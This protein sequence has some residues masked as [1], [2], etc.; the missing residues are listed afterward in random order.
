MSTHYGWAQTYNTR[1]YANTQ[2][3]QVVG[4]CVCSVSNPANAVDAGTAAPG[5]LNTASTVSADVSLLGGTVYQEYIFSGATPKPAVTQGIILKVGSGS[6]LSLALLNSISLQAYNGATPVGAKIP[7]SGGLLNL[8]LLA[9]GNQAELF[10]PAPGGTGTYDRVRITIDGGLASVLVSLNV[11]AAYYDVPATGTIACDKPIDVL[12]GINGSVGALGGVTDAYKAGDGDPATFA[13]LSAAV[14]VA[15]YAQATAIF[16]G[17]SAP[18]DSVRLLV[19]QSGSLLNLTLLSGLSIVTYNGNTE[20][21]N[22]TASSGLLTLQLLSGS[23]SIQTLSF[24]PTAAFDRI[25]VR[26]GGVLNVLSTINV[27]EIQRVGQSPGAGGSA[28]RTTCFGTPLTLNVSNPDNVNLNYTW[29]DSTQLTVVGTG[30]SYIVPGTTA[31]GKYRYYVSA[32]RKTCTTESAKA[33]VNVQVNNFATAADVTLS[34]IPAACPGD[35]IRITPTSTTANKKPIFKWY[36]DAAKTT[37]ITDGQVNGLVKYNIDTTGK[38]SVTGLAAGTYNYFV[39]VSDSNYC[40]NAANNLKQATVTVGVGPAPPTLIQTYTVSTGL[41]LT[42]VATPAPGTTVIWY[43]NDTTS[44]SFANGS[45]V[46][47]PAFTV[48][49]TYTYFA[50]DSTP[51]GCISSRLQITVTVSGPI[52]TTSC[53]VPTSQVTGTTLGCVLCSVADPLSAIDADLTNFS[54]LNIPVG[55]LGGSVYQRVIFPAPGAATDSIRLDLASPGGLADVSLLGGAVVTV[56]NGATVVSTTTLSQL[57]TLRLLSS[58]RFIATVPTGGVYDRV[59]VKLTG[60]VNLLN[61]LDIYSVRAVGPN[62]TIAAKNVTVCAGLPA[63]F[64]ATA[65]PGTSLRWYKDSTGGTILSTQPAFT[66]D[67]LK[68]AGT[69]TYYVEVVDANGCANPERIPVTATVNALG[70]PADITV[71]G[72]NVT[73]GSAVATLTPTAAGVTTPVFKWYT[74]SLR[75]TAIIN[76]AVI[77]GATFTIDAAGKLSATGLALGSHTYF[78]SVSGTNRCENA[79][80]NLKS[81]TITV[82][83]NPAPPALIQT[84]TVTTGLP[85]TLMATPAPGAT[86]IWYRNDTTGT[87]FASGS[88]ITLPPF[89]APGVYSYFA[90][91]SI[92]GGCISSRLLITITVTGPVVTTSCNVPTSQVTGTTLGCVL[93][94]VANPTNDIDVDPANFTRLNIP[95]GLLGG[96]VYQQLIFPAAGAATDSIRLDLSSPG[97]LADV[98][99]LGGAVVTVYNGAT[100][101]STTTLSQLLTL[102]LL[103]GTRYIATVPTGGAYDRVEVKLTGVVNLLNSLDIYGVRAV[104]PNPT[105]AAKNV[106][107]CA[108]Q[109]AVFNATAGPGTSL[110]WYKD[111]TGGAFLSTQPTFTTDSLKTAGAFTYYVEVVDANG[112][113]NPERIPVI[114]TVN[115]L[116][117]PADITVTGNNATCGGAAATLVPTAA[118]VTA[119]VFKWYTDSLKTT[120]IINGAVIGG[121][122]FAIDTTGKLSVSGLAQGAHTYYVSVSGSNRCENAAGSLKSATI[123]VSGAPAPPAVVQTQAISTGLPL[124]L[125]AAGAPGT[126]VLWYS[127][128]TKA[129][130]ATGDS[131]TLPPF[132][133]PGIYTYYVGDSLAGGCKSSRLPITITVTG[134]VIPADCNVPTSQVTGTTLGCILCSVQNPANDIDSVPTNFTR[135]NI[136]VGLLGGSVYQRLIFPGVRNATDSIRL[137]LASPGGLADVSVLGGAVITVYNGATVVSTH[138]LSQLLTLRLLGG[139]RYTAA[140]AAGGAYDRVEVKLTGVANLLNSL[141]IYGVRAVVPDPTVTTQNVVV[142]AGQR[143]ALTVTPAAG[144]TVRWYTDSTTTVIKSTTNTYNTDTLKVA[145]KYTFYVQAIAANGCANPNRIPVIVTVNP[146]SQAGSITVAD[147]TT[148]CTSGPAVLTPTAAAVTAPVFRW[149]KNADKTSPVT[150]GL[151]EGTVSYA[152]DSATGKLTITGLATG[153]YTYYVSVS[154]TGQ[155]ENAAGTLKPATVHVVTA[156]ATPVVTGD[157]VVTTGVKAVL[158]AQPVPGATIVWYKDATTTTVEGTGDTIQVG[159]F[160]SPGTYTYYAAVQIPGACQSARVAVNVKVTGNFIPSPDCNVPTSQTSGT[161]LGCILCSVNNPTNDIDSVKTNFTTLSVPVGALGGSV[162]QQLIFPHAGTA[163]DSVQVRLGNSVGLADVSLL[164]GTLISLYNNNTLVKTD[165][166]SRLLTLRLLNGQQFTAT[167]VAPSAYNRVE[168]KM[169]GVLNLLNSIDIYG[170]RIIYPKATVNTTSAT[171]CINTKASLSVTPAAGTSVRWYADSTSNTVL[172][173]QNTYTTDTLKVAGKVTYYVAVLGGPDNCPNPERIPVTVTVTPAPPVP[174]APATVNICPGSDAVLQVT[175]PD[176]SLTYNWYSTATGGTKLNTDSGFVFTVKAIAKDTAF[177][178]EAVSSC[179]AAS[180]RQKISIV[181]SSSLSAP[182]VSPNPDS[183][184]IGRQTAV[185]ATSNAANAQ[186]IWYGSQAGTDS[187]FTGPVFTP[188]VSNTIGT[189]TYWVEARLTGGGTCKSIRVPAVIYY[190]PEPGPDPGPCE[191]AATQTIGGSGLLILG[192]VYNPALAVDGSLST[193]SSLV[194]NLGALNAQVWERVK[195]NG[196]SAPGDTVRVWLS[197]PSQVLSAALLGGVQLTTYN[198]ATPGDSLAVNNPLIKLTLLSS[199][200]QAILEF[201]PTKP[202]DGVEVKLKSGILGALTTVDFNYA[203]RALAAPNVKAASVTACAGSTATLE[204]LAPVTGVTY[205]WYNSKGVYLTGKD[206]VSFTSGALTADTS[207]FVEAFRNNCASSGRTKVDVKVVAAPAAPV[208]RAANVEVCAGSDALL[209]INNPVKGYSY[210]WYNVANGGTRLNPVPDSGLTFI[211]KNVTAQA[212]YYV[213]AKNDSCNTTSAT[214]TAVTVNTATALATPTVTPV[215]DTIVIGQRPVFTAKAAA[216]NAE[217]SWFR[218]QTDTAVLFKGTTFEGPASTALGTVTYWVEASLPGAATCKSARIAVNAITITPNGQVPC[219]G[220]TGQ[221]IGGSGLLVLGN[222]YNPQLAVDP[223]TST[224]SSLVINLGAVNAAV[225][226]KATF[227]GLST[228]G[229]TVRVMLSNP[230]QILSASLLGSVQL[231]TYNGNT[232]GDSVLTSNPILHLNLLS[233]GRSAILSFVP[234]KPFDGVEVKLR[235]G[236]VGTLL[237]VDFNYAQRAI[238]QPKVQV[239]NAT[240]CKG[241]QATLSVINPAPGITYSWYNNK[242]NH[243]LDSIAYVTPTTLDSGVYSYTVVPTRNTCPGAAS[244]ATTVTVLGLP[245]APVPTGN[246]ASTCLNTPVTLQVKAVA[247]IQYNWYDAATGGAKLVT[248]SNQYTTPASLQAGIYNFYV[249]AVNAGNCA[250]DSGRTKITL[251]VDSAATA[252]DIQIADKV[253][254]AGDTAVLTP[255]TTTVQNP[256][257]KWYANADRTGPITQGVSNTG[258]LTITGLSAGTYTYYV[259][260]SNAGKCEN[261]AGDLKA[262]KVTVNHTSTGSDIVAADSTICANTTVKLTAAST[263]VTNPIFKWYADAALKTFL[264]SGATYTTNTLTANTSF[265]VTVEGDNRCANAPGAAK[266][267]KVTVST[268]PVPIVK[269]SAISICVGDTATLSVQNVDN[270]LTYRWYSAATAG[271]LLFTGPVYQVTGLTASKDFYAEASLGGCSSASR[272][273]ISIGVGVAP[274]PILESNNVTVCEGGTAILKVTSSIDKITY[275]WYTA[276]TGGNAVFTGPIF[277]V[278]NVTAN[279]TYYV[280]ATGD[281]SNCGKPSAR[282]AAKINVV[283][284]PA[285]PVLVSNKLD[286]CKG[287]DVTLQV[288]SPVAGATYEWYDAATNGNKVNEGPTFN[289]TALDSTRT[290]YVQAVING[291]CPSASRTSATITVN[292]IPTVPEI[293]SSSL[294]VC[295]GGS[296]TVSIKTPAAGVIYRWYDAPTGGKLLATGNSYTTGALNANTDLYA[297]A[298]NGNCSNSVRAKVSIGVGQAPTPILES[299]ALT[300]CMGTSGTLRV[301]SATNG[302][303]YKWYTSAAGN[304][305]V[306]VGPVF[307]TGNLNSTTDF[308]VEA[309]GDATKCGNASN[310]VKATVTV[311]TPPTAPDVVASALKTCAGTG[312]TVAVK[313][314]RP[315]ITYQ[316]YDALTGGH[317]LSS[318]AVYSVPVVTTNTTFYVQANQGSCSSTRTAVSVSVDPTPPI[319]SV[320]SDDLLTCIGGSVTF[321]ISNPDATVTYRWYDAPNDG[322][323]L[324]SGTSYSTKPLAATTIFYVEALNSQGCSSAR[325]AVTAEVKN[326]IDAPLADPLTVCS[327]QT[328]VLS[329]K[330]RKAGIIYKW[331]SIQRGGTEVFTGPDF[332]ITPTVSAV[333]F[334]EASTSGGCISSSRTRVEVTVN[335]APGAPAVASAT[336]KVCSGLTATLNVQNPDATLTYN[337]FTTPTGGTS[338]SSGASFTTPVVTAN[339]MYY[340]EASNNNGCSSPTRTAVSVQVTLPPAAPVVAGGDAVCPGSSATLTATSTTPDVNFRWY[341]VAT[342]GTPITTGPTFVTDALNANTTYYVEA[343]T[344]GGC[345]SSA[346]TRADIEL[347]QP[348]PAPV[349]TVDNT[350]ATSITFRWSPVT[351]AQRYEVTTDNGITFLPP[352]SGANGTTHTISGLQ[353]NQ[354]ATIQVRAIGASICQNSALSAAVTDKTKNPQGNNIFVPNLFSP[355]G[356]GINDIEYV[357]GTAIAQLE[358][359]I[360]NQWGQLVFTSKDQRQGWDGTMSGQKQPVGVYVWIVKATMQD[361]TV[362]TKK[363]N[364]TLMR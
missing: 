171:A 17:L 58:N 80:G 338:A 128:T 341:S 324:A 229:D 187:L 351:G 203:Q 334:L 206:G 343:F 320:Q 347:A 197:N 242:G 4:L 297:E 33:L 214:R 248:N 150:N 215:N 140:V 2:A 273:K 142:C 358:F 249:E 247:G 12:G 165:T 294:F 39:S 36:A 329:V 241:K 115:A 130:I 15:G 66:T 326:E 220:A 213:E 23:T 304:D 279:T 59:E 160:N 11:Y 7:L 287:G 191:G 152:L 313:T 331:F 339:Q 30:S 316:W 211:V 131:I 282:A 332:T 88:S 105:I 92:A 228:P 125:V 108:G 188:P 336:I 37:A 162:Y 61:S 153:N 330:A 178:V 183:T 164:G 146:I 157:V 111:S 147:T 236:V 345:T 84:Y 219:E 237:N 234:T 261:K 124:T 333:Y 217:F 155:C 300:I 233:S 26:L 312:I 91:D 256:V 319:P 166:L 100:V 121:A 168:V 19:S 276:L 359:R 98:S 254:C 303:T 169:T 350:T 95:V 356:D 349:V 272:T 189:V 158:S 209:A 24:K 275:K 277:T 225:F 288:Q 16:P 79:A 227:N 18:G 235:S 50:G 271:T 5:F 246:N 202:F 138:T 207:F 264:A 363:G 295:Q 205:R 315:G 46:T 353:P 38:L 25:Q 185:T 322:V 113:A 174:G 361:G 318:D 103:S 222:V 127:D 32:T 154:G 299:N 194:I 45:S 76:G 286:I 360:Y 13:A 238:A 212:T 85:L 114:A 93:C 122:T 77:G 106:T 1:V 196:V 51:G 364:V 226:Q 54:R 69:V 67:S 64:N 344:T 161:T 135:L 210:A 123:T 354:S 267:V 253:L 280:E 231:T 348:L 34:T 327:G 72:N 296:V 172:S 78:V 314:I 340:V 132:T 75:T 216:A 27:H 251:T 268:V 56:Y 136:P 145:G 252:A 22:I 156:P 137:D 186:F 133:N 151:V 357:Y 99:V 232:P 86:V 173:S 40:E 8:N 57:L 170:A 60:V 224:A 28:V 94:S 278:N 63:V 362:I 355:N 49:G 104:G 263:T 239:T 306:G 190:G 311:V 289:I 163:S 262:V 177:Y 102:R 116:G 243:L 179:G 43:R 260:V 285:A 129:A 112:C 120:A 195:F 126:I 230:G 259:S 293:A 192:N 308:Y 97:G 62:P 245:A 118:S 82:V 41:P 265:F 269:A 31:A 258:A 218:T 193:G 167:V 298:S 198:G 119:P 149:Y 201:V 274:T 325:K 83:A 176:H 250:N 9:A 71:T 310:R 73:C 134:P 317:L 328:V 48:P 109:R 47:L 35:T 283:P 141:D 352:S 302:I 323:F 284:V 182:V 65:G 266:E 281:T 21:D 117:T 110:R 335:P 14:S 175:N 184:V 292:S 52:V 221:T 291:G 309:T 68:T 208:V 180:G 96:S 74:D 346:R 181:L 70:T 81:A 342:N 270:T 107:V 301:T 337:W 223:F 148:A 305:S 321:N 10:F 87:S 257:F 139:T 244:A 101:V 307:Q 199:K 6:V 55:L 42:L 29:Y 143:A 20:V 90:G 89:T 200:K 204:V 53:N 3:N 290:Y 144:T 255:T 240:I 44:A 159:P